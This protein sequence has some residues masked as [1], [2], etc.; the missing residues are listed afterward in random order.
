VNAG[1]VLLRAAVVIVAGALS[2]LLG[3]T[4]EGLVF[5]YARS[6]GTPGMYISHW[7]FP[8]LSG[9]ELG[10]LGGGWWF[11]VMFGI[12]SFCWFLLICGVGAL[13]SRFWRAKKV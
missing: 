4:S 10:S 3:I 1:R 2:L 11:V 5:Q 13:V 12:D 8:P 7:L 6:F 9:A